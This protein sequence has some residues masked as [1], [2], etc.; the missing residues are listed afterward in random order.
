MGLNYYNV[1]S[2]Q[3]SNVIPINSEKNNINRTNPDL[4]DLSIWKKNIIARAEKMGFSTSSKKWQ[5]P[6]FLKFMVDNNLIPDENT[7]QPP[8]KQLPKTYLDLFNAINEL[9][10]DT[11][12]IK[13]FNKQNPQGNYIIV[14]K[15]SS[16][17]TVYSPDGKEIKSFEVGTGEE[18]GDNLNDGFGSLGKAHKTT[19]PGQYNFL[20]RGVTNPDYGYNIFEV[21]T[22]CNLSSTL[23][24]MLSIHQVPESLKTER[25]HKFNDGNLDNN[26]MSFGCINLLEKDFLKLANLVKN[27]DTRLYILPEEKDNSLKL[28]QDSNGEPSFEQTKYHQID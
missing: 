14:D 11:D 5:D 26:R 19:P 7:K 1:K 28:I 6:N 2:S 23:Q 8:S 17:A 24:T 9:N 3:E 20:G 25:V 16:T 21:G 12:K 13:T 4:K 22:K 27:K 10:N 18:K 15:K